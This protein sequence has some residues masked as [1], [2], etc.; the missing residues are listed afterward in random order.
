METMDDAMDK[1]GEQVH[2]TNIKKPQN[3]LDLEQQIEEIRLQKEE[4]ACNNQFEK[5]ARL[6]DT[7]K[8]LLEEL[9]L[10]KIIWKAKPN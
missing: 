10:A 7:E 1:S 3:I 9:D 5:A 2:L 6:R 4:F 8:Y